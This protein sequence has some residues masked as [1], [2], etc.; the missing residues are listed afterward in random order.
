MAAGMGLQRPNVV[1]AKGSLVS[2]VFHVEPIERSDANRALTEWEHKMGPCKRPMGIQQAHGVFA[3]GALVGVTITADLVSATCAGFTRQEAIELA[4]L[5]ASRRDLCR[6]ILRVWREFVFPAFDRP[7]AVSY[8]DEALHTGATYRFDGWV[9]LREHAH[10]GPDRH[11]QGGDKAV[12]RKGRTK[13][14]WG[15]HADS[16][17][18]AARRVF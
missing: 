14:I 16:D 1:F 6:P 5:C 15:W 3:H 8:Q 7:W 17:T 18:R 12:P 2:P 10:S 4:R 11:N 13:T 9:R